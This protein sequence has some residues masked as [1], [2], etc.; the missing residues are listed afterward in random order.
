MSLF[1]TQEEKEQKKAEKVTEFLSNK[2]ITNLDPETLNQITSTGLS[3]KW[4]AFEDLAVSLG[5]NNYENKI[6]D[7]LNGLLNQNW[8]LIKQ[9]DDLKKQ[10]AEIIKLLKN[11]KKGSRPMTP[12]QRKI[13]EHEPF[14]TT[15]DIASKLNVSITTGKRL[16]NQILADHPEQ[17][18]TLK[19]DVING[20]L[21]APKRATRIITEK[22][23]NNWYENKAHI[24]S[25]QQDVTNQ[26]NKKENQ[27]YLKYAQYSKK[28][29][30]KKLIK[31]ENALDL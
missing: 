7:G 24:K 4:N 6:M 23:F 22:D 18:I 12:E 20:K 17:I 21:Y 1:K 19:Q 31:I 27:K 13:L 5:M 15:K 29:L 26:K 10:N 9:N 28:D 11:T 16:F 14:L 2:G 8:I 3:S 25:S 30:I